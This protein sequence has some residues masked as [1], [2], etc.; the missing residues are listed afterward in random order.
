MCKVLGGHRKEHVSST[1]EHGK[2][3][4]IRMELS[5]GRPQSVSQVETADTGRGSEH[6]VPECL[7][8]RRQ[9]DEMPGGEDGGDAGE[10]SWSGEGQ[11][12]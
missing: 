11:T 4:Q 1:L 5:V 2:A 8:K 7:E 6:L 9:G 10:V 3:P 12:A